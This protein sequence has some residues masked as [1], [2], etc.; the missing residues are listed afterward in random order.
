MATSVTNPE[1]RYYSETVTIDST[2]NILQFEEVDTVNLTATLASGTY[3]WAELA[4]EIKRALEAAST[5]PA[6]YTV[7]Y[8]HSTRKYTIVSDRG[9][10]DTL[11]FDIETSGVSNT[12]WPTL[13]FTANSSGTVVATSVTQ[14]SDTAVPS[15]TTLSMTASIQCRVKRPQQRNTS[16]LE[17]TMFESG[18]RASTY[19]GD[20]DRLTFTMECLSVTDIQG[21]RDLWDQAGKFGNAIDFYPDETN[22]T[23]YVTVY[24][25]ATEFP[26][27]EMTDRNLYRLYAIEMPLLLKKPAGGTLTARDLL[28]RGPA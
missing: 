28:D 21:L 22:N 19:H 6:T 13:G 1:F 10:A 11:I 9:A 15:Q 8:S 7:S 23:D 17:V 20:V 25:D 16:A 2:N 18:R 14:T 26:P 27:V 3:F 4:Y 5:G 12:G 24:W